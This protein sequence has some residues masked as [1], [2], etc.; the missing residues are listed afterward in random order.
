ME[1]LAQELVEQVLE[2]HP[3][4]QEPW[5][6]EREPPAE[7][8]AVLGRWWSEG[9]EYVFSWHEGRLTAEPAEPGPAWIKPA[10]FERLGEREYRAVAGRE[11]G[12][13]LRIEDGRLVWA[14]YAFTREQRT[15]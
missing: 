1:I 11:R 15:F 9:E 10:V 2:L 7:L 8:R 4:A 14:G 13:R 5:R 3:P 6:P 12:E